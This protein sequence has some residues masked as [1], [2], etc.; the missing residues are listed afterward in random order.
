MF[1]RHKHSS[2]SFIQKFVLY[3]LPE[4]IGTTA[5]F[6]LLFRC[7]VLVLIIYF[8]LLVD[9]T[10]FILPLSSHIMEKQNIIKTIC[11]FIYNF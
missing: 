9:I 10:K 8:R 7:K 4:S 6:Y 3:L 11:Y 1:V 5:L 2:N